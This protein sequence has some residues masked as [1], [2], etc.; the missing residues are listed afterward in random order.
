MPHL[1]RFFVLA[2]TGA[3]RA[4]ARVTAGAL[5][6][7]ALPVGA[8]LAQ[9]D[10]AVTKTVSDPLL[11]PLAA[12]E[13]EVV[14]ENLGAEQALAVAVSDRL[15]TGL[16]IAPGTA[17]FAS[18]GTYD[19]DTGAWQIGGLGPGGKATLIVPAQVADG[20]LPPCLVNRATINAAGDPDQRNNEAAAALR[21]PDAARCVDLYVDLTQAPLFLACDNDTVMLAA[22]VRNDGT[23]AA[24][25]VRV[26][27][28]RLPDQPDGLGF[29]DAL[30]ESPSAC[31]LPVL[32]PRETVILLLSSSSGIRN[33][34]P[35]DFKAAVSAS[36][37]D[38]DYA[39][40]NETD[41]LEFTKA[42]YTQCDFG[43]LGVDLGS[44]S[45][46][47]ACFIATAAYGSAMHP[48]VVGLR[49]FREQV[50]MK[51]PAGR[52]FVAFYYRH[53]PPVARY[54]AER[55][56][57]RAVARTALWPVVILATRPVAGGLILAALLIL[58]AGLARRA[59]GR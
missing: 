58:A 11:F 29:I 5:I 22:A 59:R 39:P 30:C 8:A 23:D 38:E 48:K 57:A 45:S 9:V 2:T 34:Q 43:P 51:S 28:D 3:T 49:R 52:A 16:R 27:I 46:L 31:T 25:D 36:S 20:P 15:P 35:R 56:A 1:P 47:G 50:L 13:F 33:S 41:V 44:G 17:P 53:S 18:Q 42:P 19:P 21:Q 6:L 7:S 12:V 26:G 32:E 55:P 10:L 24:R 14:V 40:G 37:P 54:I 4:V